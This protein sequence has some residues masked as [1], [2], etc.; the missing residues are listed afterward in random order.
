MLA[1]ADG[2]YM[3]NISNYLGPWIIGHENS[4]CEVNNGN[5]HILSV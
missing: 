1:T 2:R 5:V 3:S 4:I